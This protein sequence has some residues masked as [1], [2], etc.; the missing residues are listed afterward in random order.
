MRVVVKDK[1][2]VEALKQFSREGYYATS[3]QTIAENCGI[4]KA[5]LYKYFSSKDDLLMQVFDY[6]LKQM[7]I[8]TTTYKADESFSKKEQLIDKIVLEL[9]VAKDHRPF[10]NLVFQAIPQKKTSE[11]MIMVKRTKALLMN[12]HFTSLKDAYGE[13]VKD[14]IWDLVVMFQGTLREYSHLMVDDHKPLRSREVAQQ[15]VEMIDCVVQRGGHLVP[16]LTKEVMHDYEQFREEE[17]VAS[18]EE[19]VRECCMQIR[20]RIEQ[21]WTRKQKLQVFDA[22][23]HFEQEV[24]A[25]EPKLYLFEALGRYLTSEVPIS[26]E[27]DRL[28]KLIEINRNSSNAHV[29]VTKEKK[30]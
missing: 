7:F 23:D 19:Q 24:M 15:V 8:R 22:L 1:I 5:S 2:I 30:E 14:Y 4:S 13:Q 11:I 18:I 17:T 20:H 16:L 26:T 9:D 3:V 29:D 27:L 28:R 21:K 12:W 6:N 25:E 10:A